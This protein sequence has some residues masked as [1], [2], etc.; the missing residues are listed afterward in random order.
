MIYRK[1]GS[2]KKEDRI[3]AVR[4]LGHNRLFLGRRNHATLPDF[5]PPVTRQVYDE[6]RKY[7]DEFLS[8]IEHPPVGEAWAYGPHLL[9]GT[10]AGPQVLREGDFLAQMP[11]GALAIFPAGQFRA[12]YTRMT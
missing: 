10:D 4:W 6:E 1:R 11:G 2:R 9:I 12:A 3:Q 5:A 7:D 8:L